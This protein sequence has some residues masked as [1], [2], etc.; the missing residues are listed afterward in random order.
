MTKEEIDMLVSAAGCA[1][2]EITTRELDN[3][4]TMAGN[5]GELTATK[6]RHIRFSPNEPWQL[7][8]MWNPLENDGDAF[9]L[10]IDCNITIVYDYD[11]DHV[12]ALDYVVA[13]VGTAAYTV[14]N[15]KLIVT[16]NREKQA[17]NVRKLIVEVASARG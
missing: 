4:Y 6:I 17:A 15:S 9:R 2:Y 5:R 13:E 10:M 1:K 11:C 12:R 3:S 7:M 16:D 8:S 14:S